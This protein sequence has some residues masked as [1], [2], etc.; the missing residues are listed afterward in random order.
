M[1]DVNLLCIHV[2]RVVCVVKVVTVT[3]AL[4]W[5]VHMS[6]SASDL[7]TAVQKSILNGHGKL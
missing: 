7:T 3:D 5:A 6:V 1:T 4:S 2:T